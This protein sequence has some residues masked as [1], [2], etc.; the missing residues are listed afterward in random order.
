MD[1]VTQPSQSNIEQSRY[2]EK[3]KPT[4]VI[5]LLVVTH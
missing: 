4:S 1:K 3:V 2:A 5:A